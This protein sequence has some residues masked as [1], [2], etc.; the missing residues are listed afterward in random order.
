MI[1]KI[2][3]RFMVCVVEGVVKAVGGVGVPGRQ[4]ARRSEAAEKDR[5]WFVTGTLVK[6][7]SLDSPERRVVGE[8][9][10]DAA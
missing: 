3:V 7:S 6:S 4:M 9:K 2:A 10:T 5:V 8:E 1:A